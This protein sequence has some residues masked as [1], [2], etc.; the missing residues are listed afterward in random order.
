MNKSIRVTIWNEGLHDSIVQLVRKLVPPERG[1]E[2]VGIV[3]KNYAKARSHYPE[4]IAGQIAKALKGKEGIASVQTRELGDPN[5]G[6][7]DETLATT[8]VLLWWGH[9]AHDEVTQE[10]VDK[11]Q[12]RVLDGMGLLVLHSGHLSRIF[13]RLMGTGCML[14]AAFRDER[15]RLWVVDPAHPIV[16]GLPEYIDVDGTEM[17]G[18]PFE[19]PQPDQLVFISSFEKGGEVFR[20][21]CC[22]HRQKGRIF[23]FRPGHETSPIYY[24]ENVI[25]VLYNGIR[26]AAP[27]Q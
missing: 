16:E 11:I 12:K 7:D 13:R 24:D 1:D 9:I 20:S 5:Q 15:E 25:K 21:G 26:W 18:E 2:I 10:N 4:G 22:W 6:V 17:Y 14:K 3:Q 19:I 8:D 27:A 23:Y